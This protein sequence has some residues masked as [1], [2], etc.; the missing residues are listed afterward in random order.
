[1][2]FFRALGP[3]YA[4]EMF[5]TKSD[6]YNLTLFLFFIKALFLLPLSESYDVN[7]FFSFF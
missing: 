1:M 6:D 4:F 5:K 7:D 2:K 3:N